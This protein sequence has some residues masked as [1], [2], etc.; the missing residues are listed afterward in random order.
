M[1]PP[2]PKPPA[3]LLAPK[4][5]RRQLEILGLSRFRQE[6]MPEDW[7]TPLSDTAL[8]LATLDALIGMLERKL[9]PS[10]TA[11]AALKSLRKSQPPN[12]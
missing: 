2:P 11:R 12:P 3:P 8:G 5:L 6:V 4:E 9:S 10:K 7:R 1:N